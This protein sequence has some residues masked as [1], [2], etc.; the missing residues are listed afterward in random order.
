MNKIRLLPCIGLLLGLQFFS[1]RFLLTQGGQGAAQNALSGPTLEASPLAL[2]E[3]IGN[4]EQKVT[5]LVKAKILDVKSEPKQTRANLAITMVYA[6]PSSLIGRTFGAYD[7]NFKDGPFD[8]LPKLVAGQE[9]ICPVNIFIEDV[10]HTPFNPGGDVP[11]QSVLGL[12]G[13]AYSYDIYIPVLL[14]SSPQ[15][16]ATL[17]QAQAV[18]SAYRTP[19][20]KLEA[21]MTQYARA[22]EGI[23]ALWAVKVLAHWNRPSTIAVLRQLAQETD[24]PSIQLLVLE[25]QLSR[26]DSEKWLRSPA[27]MALLTHVYTHPL[28]SRESV[29]A[30]A[31]LE[32]AAQLPV[33][34]VGLS[35]DEILT[36]ALEFLRNLTALENDTISISGI[37]IYLLRSKR[38]SSEQAF[39][40]WNTIWNDPNLLI[41]ARFA[42]QEMK[43]IAPL[44]A[45]QKQALS[46]TVT[47]LEKELATLNDAFQKKSLNDAITQLKALL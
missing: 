28:T 33:S 3:L 43:E 39:T 34:R 17:A 32:G 26:V 9:V 18:A 31:F 15:A 21:L 6:G 22:K 11:Q 2:P 29:S 45:Q 41:H 23:S 30:S 7:Y 8:P 4:N 5:W 36:F 20:E 46:R 37:P 19:P 14:D 13:G 12:G 47:Y 1:P 44:D 42:G 35:G 10:P 24:R 16:Q 27:R 40:F 38:I 25:E